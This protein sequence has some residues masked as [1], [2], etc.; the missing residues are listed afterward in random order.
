MT[1][2]FY[3]YFIQ[4][5]PAVFLMSLYF[6]YHVTVILV[7]YFILGFSSWRLSFIAHCVIQFRYIH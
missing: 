4:L 6:L 2:L 5:I 3:I 1:N 7:V